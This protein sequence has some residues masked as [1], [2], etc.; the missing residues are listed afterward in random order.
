MADGDNSD[1]DALPPDQLKSLLVEKQLSIIEKDKRINVLNEQVC[2]LTERVH[3]LESTINNQSAAIAVL[4][5]QFEDSHFQVS[6]KIKRLNGNKN[7]FPLPQTFNNQNDMVIGL[8]NTSENHMDQSTNQMD[9]DSISLID[10]NNST[11]NA[12]ADV[13]TNQTHSSAIPAIPLQSSQ[14]GFASANSTFAAKPTSARRTTRHTMPVAGAP[15]DI[16]VLHDHSNTNDEITNGPWQFVNHK[17]KKDNKNKIPPIQLH[18]TKGGFNAC[19]AALT[20]KFGPNQFTISPRGDGTGARIFPATLQQH[21]EMSDYLVSQ[22][23]DFHTFL[24]ADQKR[25]CFMIRGITSEHGFNCEDIY[26][27]LLRAGFSDEVTV[28]EHITAS[29]KAKQSHSLFKITVSSNFDE[30]IFKSIRSL[31]GIAIR[32]ERFV[33]GAITQCSRCQHYF[34]T[35]A[36][37]HRQYRCVK[38]IENHSPGQCNKSPESEPQCVNCNGYHTANN[39]QKCDYFKNNIQPV[40]HKRNKNSS[41]NTTITNQPKNNIVKNTKSSSGKS[42]SVAGSSWSSTVKDNP[43]PIGGRSSR[44]AQ[45]DAQSFET[46]CSLLVQ[47][48]EG[49]NKIISKLFNNVN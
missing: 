44:P 31:H 27:E 25:K 29:M 15:N 26:D 17:N 1:L 5:K 34:H 3:S 7:Q 23:Y 22:A 20:R 32:F 6:R 47:M 14:T 24:T 18:F 39:Y 49:Q 33:S 38:C 46:L 10:E 12:I 9:D 30:R 21:S 11:S 43:G 13:V 19:H 36:A 28:L 16:G 42:A 40:I 48:V 4:Q 35:A 45:G 37:C 41:D 8:N 2:F